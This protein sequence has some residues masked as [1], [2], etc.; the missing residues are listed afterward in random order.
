MN[1][2][3]VNLVMW[4]ETAH[5]VKGDFVQVSGFFLEG[6]LNWKVIFPRYQAT[7][8]VAACCRA[9]VSA[10]MADTGLSVPAQAA[11]GGEATF[12]CEG[13]WLGDALFAQLQAQQLSQ[14]IRL[15][16]ATDTLRYGIW[17]G[18]DR[19]QA[20]SENAFAVFSQ[21]FG[22]VDA[23]T[24]TR[25]SSAW[26]NYA[27]ALY[28]GGSLTVDQRT[29]AAQPKR[30]LVVNTGLSAA[31]GQTQAQLQAAVAARARERLAEHKSLV[32]IEATV[33]QSHLRY[34]RD[35]DLG[36]RCDVRDDRLGLAFETRII[37]VNEVF[38]GG[39]H[40][41]TLQFGDKIPTAYNRG[42]V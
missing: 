42:R 38:K 12:D 20:Q 23:L 1:S 10:H 32:N 13:E 15:E 3:R 7:G 30:V 28:E 11:P 14:Y 36:D 21:H 31:Q 34:L 41:V 40:S 8:D 29:D 26:R 17:Q 22:T 18:K 16:Y 24:L 4:L 9:L 27:R 2:G 35:Y 5:S 39:A 33:L 19:T 6:M 25:D 37:E